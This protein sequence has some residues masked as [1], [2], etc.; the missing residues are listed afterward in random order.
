MGTCTDQYRRTEEQRLPIEEGWT[1][2]TEVTTSDEIAAMTA[3]V[4]AA[5]GVTS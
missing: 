2:P 5:A 3:L 1:R 4:M